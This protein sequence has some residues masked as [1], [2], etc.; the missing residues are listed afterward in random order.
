MMGGVSCEDEENS[1]SPDGSGIFGN[2]SGACNLEMGSASR[3]KTFNHSVA[4]G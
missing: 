1:S 4:D 2:D 3:R